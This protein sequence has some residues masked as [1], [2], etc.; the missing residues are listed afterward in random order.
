MTSLHHRQA[1][2]TVTRPHVR[3][4]GDFDCT[5]RSTR[6]YVPH[7]VER[8]VAF[9]AIAGRP[10]TRAQLAGTLWPDVRDARAYGDLRSALWRLRRHVDLVTARQDRVGLSS[11]VVVDLQDLRAL[12]DR[13]MGPGRP[14]DLARV[15]ELIDARDLLVGWDEEWLVVERERYRE[16]RMHALE[17]AAGHLLACGQWLHAMLATQAVIATD[18]FRESAY[19][20]AIK[21][22][23]AEGNPADAVRVDDSYRQLIFDELGV[24]PS[25]LMDDLR[26]DAGHRLVRVS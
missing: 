8:I 4:T 6:I 18:P 24:R 26:Q 20:L 21:I 16:I 23:L 13:L 10:V 1:A 11:N 12:A 7:S 5:I 22:H 2:T 17:R 25:R 14:D 3:L 9:L 19:R 15:A